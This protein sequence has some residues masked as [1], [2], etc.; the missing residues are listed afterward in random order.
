MQ[1]K[2]F[3]KLLRKV[4]REEVQL[5][6]RKELRTILNEQ[7]TDHTQ[8]INHGISLSEMT[9]NPKS[10]KTYTKNSMLNDILNET[11]NTPRSQEMTDYSTMNFRSDMAQSFGMEP[12]GPQPLATQGINGEAVNMSNEGVATVVKAMT[13][14]YSGMMKA[15]N[16][17]DKQKGKKGING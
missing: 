2:S 3:V 6:V 8:V 11:A 5:V 7:K 10:K 15:M 12:Q 9:D 4:I 13:K 17:L 1:A 14:D 16:K